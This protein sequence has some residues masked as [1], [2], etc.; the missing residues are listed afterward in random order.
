MGVNYSC[1]LKDDMT[2]ATYNAMG[3]IYSS[4]MLIAWFPDLNVL[5]PF[6]SSPLKMGPKISWSAVSISFF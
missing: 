6:F 4:K 2:T 5:K 3:I 1:S